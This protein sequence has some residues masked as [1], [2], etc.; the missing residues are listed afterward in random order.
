MSGLGQ[1]RKLSAISSFSV[2]PILPDGHSDNISSIT[3]NVC[4]AAPPIPCHAIWTNG[5][6]I[7]WVSISGKP[8]EVRINP[9]PFMAVPAVVIQMLDTPPD[10]DARNATL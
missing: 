6:K 9:L 7:A 5:P 10:A 8:P 1:G 2:A 4:D 3:V